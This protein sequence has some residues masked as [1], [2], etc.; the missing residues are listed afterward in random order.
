MLKTFTTGFGYMAFAGLAAQAALL[1]G[2]AK[3]LGDPD[4]SAGAAAG[5]GEVNLLLPKKPHFPARAKRIIFL[6]MEGAPSHVDTFDYKP[7]LQADDGK[8]SADNEAAWI[9]A[10]PKLEADWNTF[11]ASVNVYVENFRKQREQQQEIFEH[12]AA[13]QIKAWREAGDKLTTDAKAFAADRRGDFDAAVVRMNAEAAAAQEKLHKLNH[14]GTQSWT[15]LMAALSETRGVF[16]RA[17]Q[18]AREAFKRAA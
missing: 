6:G 10:K 1:Q 8:Q 15:A 7:K 13:A 14:A 3:V 4:A 9:S 11:E 5:G 18:A 2:G 17:S 16:D 12:Q